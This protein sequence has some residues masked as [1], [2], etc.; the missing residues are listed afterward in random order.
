MIDLSA[1]MKGRLLW[2]KVKTSQTPG[3]YVALCP[4]RKTKACI[5]GAYGKG[6]VCKALVKN[7]FI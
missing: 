5:K 6:L 2:A 7:R 1:M 3:R 4:L